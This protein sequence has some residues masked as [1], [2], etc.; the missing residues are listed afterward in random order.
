M[1]GDL[2]VLGRVETILFLLTIA[3]VAAVILK[4][5]K[6]PYTIGLVPVGIAI[7]AL[8]GHFPRLESYRNLQL[9]QELIMYVLLPALIFDAS[10]NINAKLLRRNLYPTLM[11]AAPGLVI[12]TIVTGGM[13][14]F[15][16]NLSLGASMIFGALISATDPV[17]VISLFELVGAPRR[18]RILVDGESLFNDATAIAMYNV[19]TKVVLAAAVFNWTTIASGTVDFCWVFVGGVMIGLIMGFV[20]TQVM[21]WAGDDPHIKIALSILLAFSTFLIADRIFHLSGVMA[22]LAAGVVVSYYSPTKF[23]EAAR[24]QLHNF[25]AFMSFLANSAIFLLLGF[26]ET[27][28]LFDTSGGKGILWAIVVGIL[29]IQ[30]ARILVVFGLCPFLGKG[31]KKISFAYQVVMFW[32]GLRGAVPLALVFSIPAD[33]PERNAILQITLAVVLFT[34]VAQ[35]LTTQK[36]LALFKLDQPEVFVRFSEWFA[37]LGAR[38]AGLARICSLSRWFPAPLVA[39]MRAEYEKKVEEA[40]QS[41]DAGKEETLYAL[42]RLIWARAVAEEQGILARYLASGLLSESACRRLTRAGGTLIEEIEENAAAV[43]ARDARRILA[44]CPPWRLKLLRPGGL[45]KLSP[46]RQFGMMRDVMAMYTTLIV[47]THHAEDSLDASSDI[48]G[49][50]PEAVAACRK[51]FVDRRRR[52]I[53]G[54]EKL[55][56]INPEQFTRAREYALRYMIFD[57]ELETIQNAHASGAL[58]DAEFDRLATFI[59]HRESESLA[60]LRVQP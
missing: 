38:R 59:H 28:I 33:Y 4:R 29:S 25:W 40:Q 5:L 57:I 17:A 36:L 45:G 55:E 56:E 50:H 32:G 31:E 35:G 14:Y 48:A 8:I 7:A 18:L 13:M 49:Q 16:T 20:M 15:M 2:S 39:S 3:T 43:P 26:T 54:L 23:S 30:V 42:Q 10:I 22:V 60:P 27:N 24:T 51:F 37:L 53:R 9:G 47:A 58:D 1:S 34:L 12:A 11:L 19:V 41:L 6:I 21:A 52:L 46:K 44:L